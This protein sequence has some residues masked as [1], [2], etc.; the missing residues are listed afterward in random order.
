MKPSQTSSIS[1]IWWLLSS[2]PTPSAQSSRTSARDLA[3]TGRVEATGRLVEQQQLWRAQQGGRDPQA[4][5]H[6]GGVAAHPVA[7][8]LGQPD[9]VEHRVDALRR[10]SPVELSEQLQV[11]PTR[12]V[13]VEGRILDEPGNVVERQRPG[14]L[15]A[16]PEQLDRSSVRH[17]QAEQQSQQGR[18]PSA[19]RAEQAMDLALLN[20]QI[21]VIQSDRGLE[22]LDQAAC[23][24]RRHRI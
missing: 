12:Q 16:L 20:Q 15:D 8:A 2:T 13:G 10:L 9:L 21:R 4:L 19:V 17:D 7:A 11:R 6:P 18:L 3:S 24:Y 5:A 23:V 14:P 22:A 1:P